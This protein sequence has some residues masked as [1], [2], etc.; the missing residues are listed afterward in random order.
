[1]DAAFGSQGIPSFVL[2]GVLGEL[3]AAASTYLS[4]LASGMSLEL[5]A[6]KLTAAA[7][8]KAKGK[9]KKA[10][11]EGKGKGAAKVSP[12]SLHNEGRMAPAPAA[13][14]GS[15]SIDDSMHKH[16]AGWRQ[17]ESYLAAL[18]HSACGGSHAKC[19]GTVGT[20]QTYAHAACG[21]PL[22]GYPRSHGCC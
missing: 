19:T 13:W 4:Q 18:C 6:T 9:A 14:G 8:A 2:E 22:I 12:T 1:V 17:T 5:K 11:G 7:A 21:R 15:A 20:Q 10:A 16:P 3:Q